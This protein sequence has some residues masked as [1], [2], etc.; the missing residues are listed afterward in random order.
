[1]GGSGW[2]GQGKPRVEKKEAGGRKERGLNAPRQVITNKK[3]KIGRRGPPHERG[4]GKKERER[5]VSKR[6][7][8]VKLPTQKLQGVLGGKEK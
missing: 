2:V 1:M 8:E 5:K 4:Y 7:P 3:P 6:P